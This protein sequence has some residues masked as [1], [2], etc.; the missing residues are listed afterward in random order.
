[1]TMRACGSPH[2]G[3]GRAQYAS[4][5]HAGCFFRA[6]AMQW[7]RSLGQASQVTMASRT[8]RR[9]GERAG[10]VA[11]ASAPGSVT[12]RLFVR[13]IGRPHERTRLH[14]TETEIERDAL[15]LPELVRRIEAAHR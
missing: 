8:V 5:R 11:I 7:L 14:M 15:E 12:V 10:P 13:V 6:T 3:T 9:A 4:W 1:S 2:P